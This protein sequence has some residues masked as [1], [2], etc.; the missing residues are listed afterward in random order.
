MGGLLICWNV[1]FLHPCTDQRRDLAGG[2]AHNQAAV[3]FDNIMAAWTVKAGI[4]AV[5]V[6]SNRILRLVAIVAD[7]RRTGDPLQNAFDAANAAQGIRHLAFLGA[8]FFFIG[9]VLIAAPAT[10]ARVRAVRINAVFGAHKD[11]LDASKGQIFPN[12]NNFD[13]ALIPD[14]TSRDEYRHAVNVC[15]GAAPSA[16]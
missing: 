10:L 14:R 9:N 15:D 2:F 16:V 5:F 7:L 3:G 13:I 11:L 4:R 12:L 1:V 6:L 8:Q